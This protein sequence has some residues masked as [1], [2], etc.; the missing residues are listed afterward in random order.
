V[1]I[2]KQE[3]NKLADENGFGIELLFRLQGIEYGIASISDI[4]SVGNA[5]SKGVHSV[6]C[7]LRQKGVVSIP[8]WDEILRRLPKEVTVSPS[9]LFAL[10]EEEPPNENK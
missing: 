10:A 9:T 6:L 2:N 4:H 7:T 1:G 3:F 5:I 8:E